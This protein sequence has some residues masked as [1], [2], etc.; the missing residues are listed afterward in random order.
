MYGFIWKVKGEFRAEIR[1]GFDV[2]RSTVK[3]VKQFD[4]KRDSKRWL[5]ANGAQIWNA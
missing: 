5:R 3:A 2:S 1:D 4:S